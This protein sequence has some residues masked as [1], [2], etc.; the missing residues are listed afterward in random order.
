MAIAENAVRVWI[1]ITTSANW[2]RPAVGVIRVERALAEHLQKQLGQE[3]CRLCVW[4]DDRFVEWTADIALQSPDMEQ[5]LNILLPRSPSF[6]LARSFVARALQRF[7]TPSD[8][9]HR[10]GELRFAMPIK[11]DELPHPLPGDI[12]ISAGLDWDYPYSRELYSL[13]K[14]Q[15]LRIITCCYDLIPVL[16][17]HYCVGDVAR[18]FTEYFMALSWGSEAVLCISE[19]TRRDYLHL[20]AELGA[21]LRRTIVIP[22]GDNLPAGG[23][24]IGAQVSAVAQSPFILYVS[25]IERRK[26]HDVLYRAYHLLSRRDSAAEL[27]ML[28]FV[29]MPG[30]GIGDLMKDIE[31]DPLVQGKIIQ[32]N[33]VTD[34]ELAFLYK[35]ALFCVF[36]SLYEGWGLPVGE[37]LSMGK[38]VISS[39]EASLPEVGGDLVRYVRPW[40]AY[41]WANAIDEYVKKPDLVRTAESRVK[42]GYV[43]RKWTDTAATVGELLGEM[44]GNVDRRNESLE[45]LPGYDLE[46]ECGIPVGPSILTTGTSG[47]LLRGPRISMRGGKYRVK[48]MGNVLAQ[49]RG[50][51]DFEVVSG[52][53]KDMHF[54]GRVD[55][56]KATDGA[57]IACEFELTRSVMDVEFRCVVD[58]NCAIQLDSIQIDCNGN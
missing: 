27:P 5:A 35:N 1:N 4:K 40:D 42:A 55:P 44:I 46:T 49:H 47:V 25:T 22:L 54:K 33:H 24:E 7:L 10:E 17:P 58:S 23:A 37:A 43:P 15:G 11:D 28:V 13:A 39:G 34:G 3:R 2:N 50:T 56:D 21:P 51:V 52:Q 19:Q 36:P 38:A 12:L 26:N 6:D 32:L 20:C 48:I 31:L 30:W 53:R 18:S 16:F 41:A 9:S 14:R 29:G 8:Y 45:F 57:L